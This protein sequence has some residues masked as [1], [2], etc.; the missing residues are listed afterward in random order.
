[1]PLSDLQIRNAK[2]EAKP[3]KLTDANGLYL[4]VLPT[5]RKVWRYD[6]QFAGKRQTLT[7]GAWP[8]VGLSAARSKRDAARAE[9]ASGRDPR[10]KPAAASNTFREVAERWLKSQGD[11][12]SARTQ[13]RIRT[14]L[15][16]DL[17]P[18]L[19]DREIAS[20]ETPELL[21]AIRAMEARGVR[22]QAHR[23]RIYAGKVFRFAI[24]EGVAKRD[25]AADIRDA[26]VRK[27]KV[28][29]QSSLTEAE[30]PVFL[31]KLDAE[32]LDDIT[33]DA[34]LFTI[35]TAC[36]T[37]EVRFA[38]A[39]EFSDLDGPNPLWEVPAARMKMER[40][41]VVPLSRQAAEIA[42]RWVG[43]RDDGMLFGAAT[44]SGVI[45]ENTMLF[46]LYRLGYHSKATV[47]G[48][49]GTFSTIANEHEWNSDWVELSLAHV[50]G[51][52]RG[53]YNAARYLN[54][55]RE[56]LQWWAD[57]IDAQRNS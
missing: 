46:A 44:V 15:N 35:L 38:H 7:F 33:R 21:E 47:H 55:R 54:Q 16:N 27:P 53:A 30:L 11:E 31:R 29:H 28:R 36:R 9:I 51:G 57:F 22:E 14:I 10:P 17:Y 8:D 20:I 13:Q 25:P 2:P 5:G 49:R 12:L 52:V 26:L 19:G 40:D 6:Y 45:S 3:R 32:P 4:S 41:H 23:A 43:R 50:Q 48:F 18:P 34:L 39:R 1:M 24:A 37:A 56:L 42:R